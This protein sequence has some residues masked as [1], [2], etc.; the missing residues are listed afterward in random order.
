MKVYFVTGHRQIKA[1]ELEV[2][3]TSK[4]YKTLDGH[5]FYKEQFK[6]EHENKILTG[7]H[8]DSFYIYSKNAE[9]IPEMVKRLKDKII[10]LHE[11]RIEVSEDIIKSI[12]KGLE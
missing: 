8:Y 9:D 6:K 2:K 7:I 1:K 11:N 10:D 12:S 4:L 5:V 3:E